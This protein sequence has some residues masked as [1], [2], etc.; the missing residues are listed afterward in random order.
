MGME[1]NP[2]LS[3]AIKNDIGLFLCFWGPIIYISLIIVISIS[4]CLWPFI[5]WWWYQIIKTFKN[6]VTLD[7]DSE[8]MNLKYVIGLGLKYRFNYKGAEIEHI[9]SLVSN[10]NMKRLTSEPVLSIVY[11][12]DKNIS[13]IR[14]VYT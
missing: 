10:K 8:N 5:I 1:L 9:A 12:P 13:F 11:N 7:A 3:S 4:I 2:K 14:N 6:G